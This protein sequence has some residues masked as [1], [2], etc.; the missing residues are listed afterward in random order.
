MACA[1][2]AAMLNVPPLPPPQ[3]INGPLQLA[4]DVGIAIDQTAPAPSSTETPCGCGDHMRDWWLLL[5]GLG[6]G[7]LF[8]SKQ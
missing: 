4:A 3:P 8:F 5:L 6:L 2:G 7:Y 1:C